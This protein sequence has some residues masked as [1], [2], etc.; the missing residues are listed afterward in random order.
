MSR[1]WHVEHADGREWTVD[2][3]T[4]AVRAERGHDGLWPVDAGVFATAVGHDGRVYALDDCQAWHM[5]DDC[6]VVWDG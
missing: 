5:L 3:L 6:E 4:D 2:E 1:K